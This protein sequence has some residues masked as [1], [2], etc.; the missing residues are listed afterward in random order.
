MGMQSEQGIV[1]QKEIAG[2]RVFL[3]TDREAGENIICDTFLRFKGLERPAVIVT[4]LRLVSNLYE[5][6]MHIAVSR[7][8]NLL[9]IVGLES[10]IQKHERLA[11]LV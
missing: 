3:A 10:E 1:H 4:D 2:H 6:R 7:A 8:L 11:G 5:K 9:R